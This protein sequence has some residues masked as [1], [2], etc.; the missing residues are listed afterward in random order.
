M[1]GVNCDL[2][3]AQVLQVC[4]S[5]WRCGG[6]KVTVG[7]HCVRFGVCVCVCVRLHIYVVSAVNVY[8]CVVVHVLYMRM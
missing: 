4:G 5:V 2:S 7:I 6:V 8:A 1:L 3:T